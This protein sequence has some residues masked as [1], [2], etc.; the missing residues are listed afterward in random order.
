M[1][2][3][4]I[5]DGT[6]EPPI[7]D[8]HLEQINS[9]GEYNLAT[10][11]YE[12]QKELTDQIV[13]LHYPDILK[14]CET[15]ADTYLIRKSLEICVDNCIL[16]AS[17]PYLLIQHYMPRNL[18]SKDIPAKI[19]ETSG[20][21]SVLRDIMNVIFA[22]KTLAGLKNV[23]LVMKNENR[24]FD[25][26]EALLLG[27]TG[28][29]TVHRYVG[30]NIKKDGKTRSPSRDQRHTAVHLLP[31]DGQITR[32]EA[33]LR[34]TRF[35]V[36][37]VLDAHVNENLVF[38]KD[39]RRQNRRGEEAVLLRLIPIYTIEHAKLMARHELLD[40]YLYKV[41]SS[42][43]CLRDQIGNLP[44]DI[45]PIYNKNLKFL[46][47]TFVDHVF[48]RDLRL[49]PSWPL[50]E[51]PP[52][53]K[54]LA[55]DVER[56][57]LTEVVYHY[58]PY[59]S[60]DLSTTQVKKKSYYETKRL[61]LDYVTNPIKNDYE[62]LTGIQTTARD[63]QSLVLTHRLMLELNAR[64]LDLAQ[65]QE[66]YECL[67]DYNLPERQQ[68]VGRREHDLQ[69]TLAKIM[70]DV[71]HVESRIL[72]TEKKGQ[73]KQEAAEQSREQVQQLKLQLHGL[74]ES[75]GLSDE[76]KVKFTQN[77]IR[78]WELQNSVK[79]LAGTIKT[80]TDE[81]HYMANE[82]ANCTASIE[83][84][85]K[86]EQEWEVK[87]DDLKRKLAT[88]TENEEAEAE[89]FK[90]RKLALLG[91]IDNWAERNQALKTKLAKSLVFLKD[92]SHIKKRKGR[93]LTPK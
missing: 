43:V 15:T 60:A 11:M 19:A 52:I 8:L 17:H 12:F 80:K 57:L 81:N 90:Q 24:I 91:E 74:V 29:R 73:R 46:A 35:D 6:P 53:P 56:S 23:A 77:Q 93:G 1:D 72:V 44:P 79:L 45:V 31:G 5:L 7:V 47:H 37:V 39:L 78:I 71:D 83:A 36:V 10:P 18:V 67:R 85:R 13:L 33:E 4:S 64:Y 75:L 41:I 55:I 32:L 87:V 49:F 88:A 65:V 22:C 54:F 25:L 27:C 86:L 16:V 14:Y 61:Q 48:R 21:F 76:A 50:P 59:D 82:L 26:T 51:L 92:T 9:S 3:L 62:L 89:T 70:D 28:S 30:N 66:E 63:K 40:S 34:A 38:F 68:K 58:T 84:S 69:L 42:I 2:L 20:K